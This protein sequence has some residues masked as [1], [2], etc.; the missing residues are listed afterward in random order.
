QVEAQLRLATRESGSFGQAQRDVRRIATETRTSLE[1]TAQLYATFQRNAAEL[2]VSQ[3]QSARA[4]ETVTKAFRI[5]GATAAEA[6]GGLR[7]FLQ[8]IQ[9]GTLR[10]EELNSVLENAPRLA[11]LIADSLGVTIGQLRALGQEGNLAGDKLIRALTDRK[12]TESIDAE[13]RE[14]PVTFGEAMQQVENAAMI[15]FG[16]FDRG[17]AFS[18][19][20]A[21]F[22]TDGAAGFE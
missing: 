7:Q 22:V 14:L 3:E 15:T 16:A 4:T 6:A 20:L 19:M 10:G 11:R 18:Q 1:A 13:F 2:G 21:N 5:S 8:G 17:G 9:S 12:F